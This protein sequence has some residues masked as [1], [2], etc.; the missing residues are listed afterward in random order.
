MTTLEEAVI[1]AMLEALPH[2]DQPQYVQYAVLGPLSTVTDVISE[3]T[4]KAFSQDTA[5]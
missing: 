2:S 4:A 5:E 1:L 3:I